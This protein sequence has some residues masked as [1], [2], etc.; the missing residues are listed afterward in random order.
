MV[1]E[2]TRNLILSNVLHLQFCTV[3]N[4]VHVYGHMSYHRK[5]TSVL[6]Y[7]NLTV[8]KCHDQ[9]T[10]DVCTFVL[11]TLSILYFWELY[12]LLFAKTLLKYDM[13]IFVKFVCLKTELVGLKNF[14]RTYVSF[15]FLAILYRGGEGG[16]RR[17][18]PPFEGQ[19]ILPE[20]RI[21]QA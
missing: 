14:G 12:F 11:K 7:T 6:A 18:V 3:H 1:I 8:V 16:G 9:R 4:T 19:G 15:F 21:I 10:F 2:G 17:P 13:K 20:I 5:T